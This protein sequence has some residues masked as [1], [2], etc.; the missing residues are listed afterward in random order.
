M[1]LFQKCACSLSR[2]C[3]PWYKALR[4]LKRWP[5][6]VFTEDRRAGQKSSIAVL[7]GVR[8]IAILLVI[9][10]HIGYNTVNGWFYNKSDQLVESVVTA[11]ASGV[12]LFFILSGFLLFLPY[13][14]SLVSEQRWPLARV[15]YM[16]RALRI[17]PGY[18]LSLF[19]LILVANR[20]YL[21]ASHL[22]EDIAFFTLFLDSSLRT[23]RHINGPYWTL[24][25]EW[26]FYLLLPLLAL[27]FAW[28]V[29]HFPFKY[30]IP[31]TV[32]CLLG[33]ITWA[34]LVRCWGFYYLWHP[35]QTFL[36]PRPTL[37]WILFFTY[38]VSGK[39]TEDFA[40]G[41]LVSLC[42]IYAKQADPMRAFSRK[43]RQLSL[44]LL[45]AGLLVLLFAAMWQYNYNFH[46]WP[47]LNDPY[48]LYNKFGE[49]V[50]SLGYGSCMFA[51]LLGPDKLRKSLEWIWLRRIGLISYSLYIWHL[52]L[53]FL[54]ESR[55]APRIPG[56]HADTPGLYIG[57]WLWVL[58]VVFPFCLFTY[59]FV[60]KPGIRLSNR[61]HKEIEARQ[62]AHKQADATSGE[63]HKVSTDLSR[64][65]EKVG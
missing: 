64:E 58:L 55:I 41:M 49:I 15:F 6:R 31:V 9:T 46:G 16:R 63:R 51:L 65:K 50:L 62:Y 38:G 29:R 45:G 3:T 48:S 42:Y 33:A 13:A 27:I 35:A 28:I 44:P 4:D 24:A 14:R 52:P 36:V 26:Q 56:L 8:G 34:L 57:T 10:Y 7:D 47:F 54:F 60:E 61:W 21:T 18:Y 59:M 30:R 1:S 32:A 40:T 43:A 17:L 39:Y 20:Q 25:I 22:K 11:G 19:V 2:P 53:I 12:T 5:D 23:W 37:N